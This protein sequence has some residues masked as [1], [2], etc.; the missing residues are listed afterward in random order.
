LDSARYERIKAICLKAPALDPKARREYLDRECAGDPE[1]LERV[2]SLLESREESD[3]ALLDFARDRHEHELAE[4]SEGEPLAEGFDLVKQRGS[5]AF[6]TVWEARDRALGRKVALKILK[7][8]PG[9]TAEARRS[10]IEEARTLASIQ[11]ENVVRIHSIV[12]DDGKIRLV[13]EWIDGR[14]LTEELE[15]RGP[16]SPEEAAAVGVALCRALAALHAKGLVHRDVKPSNVIRA[17]GGRV[18]LL[19]FGLAVSPNDDDG[20]VAGTPVTM[21]PEQVRV[22]ETVSAQSDIYA[23]GVLLY[24]MVAGAYPF[25]AGSTEAL[26]R[27]VESGSMIPLPD[28]RPDVPPAFAEIVGHAMA[29]DPARR[30]ASTGEL[31]EALLAFQ[32]T[33]RPRR[34]VLLT[35]GALLVIGAVA[36]PYVRDALAPPPPPNLDVHLVAKRDGQELA[37]GP[38]S[39]VHAGDRITMSVSC[40]ERVYIYVFNEDAEG[41]AGLIYPLQ[42]SSL[43]NPLPPGV[44]ALPGTLDGATLRWPLTGSD[45][46]ETFTLFA[47]RAP[48][49]EV[50]ALALRIGSVGIADRND[51]FANELPRGIDFAET[52]EPEAR[53]ATLYDRSP[54]VET[55]EVLSDPDRS[56]LT[57]RVPH[58]YGR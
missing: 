12:E 35:L 21:S 58:P 17:R 4:T 50:Q 32:G 42:G 47:S 28:I 1:L 8:R 54:V 57:W 29:T 49:P 53:A 37:L 34:R 51:V 23:V 22:G 5:G 39:P 44:H 55:L 41:S 46:A 48:L 15:A 33:K 43:R 40:D 10:F 27:E 6:G 20:R 19:D 14:T 56:V 26:M 36:F 45:G 52:D 31:L 7:D 30:H 13:M 18:V 9:R 24:W 16:S 3:D 11:H 2:R 25:E 38:G